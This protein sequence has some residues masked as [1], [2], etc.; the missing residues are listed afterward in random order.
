LDAMVM[1]MKIDG[2]RA[3]DLLSKVDSDRLQ[4]YD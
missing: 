4:K 1:Q 3:R 2:A